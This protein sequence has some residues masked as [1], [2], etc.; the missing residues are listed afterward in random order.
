[1]PAGSRPVDLPSGFDIGGGSGAGWGKS[2]DGPVWLPDPGC[3]S[4]T[5]AGLS[6]R[7]TWSA[8]GGFRVIN[9][10]TGRAM[11]TAA[12]PRGRL[13]ACEWE[14]GRVV[15]H[16]PGGGLTV[17]AERLDGRRLNHPD[18]LAIASDGTVYF[19]DTR[20]VTHRAAAGDTIGRSGVYRLTPG[21]PPQPLP[22]DLVEPGGVALSPAED[23]LYV[24]DPRTSRVLALP[25][26][27]GRAAARTLATLPIGPGPARPLGIAVDRL[28]NLYTGGP[29]GV[30]VLDA[31]GE[32]LGV[33]RH[34]ASR[35][36]N[37]AFGGPEGR[38]LFITSLVGA[39]TVEVRV[40]GSSVPRPA[41]VGPGRPLAMPVTVER[42][43]P[44][45][46]RVIAPGTE[47]VEL[48]S[49][50]FSTDLGGGDNFWSRSLEGT[51]WSHA[52]GALL[53]SDIGNSRILRWS[54]DGVLSVYR[55][56]TGHANG[57][58]LDPMGRLVS[59][60]QGPERRV[61][62]LEPDGTVTV[63]ADSWDGRRLGRPNDVVVA[64]DGAIYFTAP[65][66]DFG[67]GATREIE[68][69]GVFRVSPDLSTVSPVVRDFQTPNGL[70]FSVD[71]KVLFV[72]D[73]ARMQIRGFAVR[74]D[75]TLDLAT[76]RVFFQFP[77]AHDDGLGGP[78]GMKVDLEG[79]VY[80]GGPGGLWIIDP[81]GRHLGTLRHGATQTNNLCFGD[82]DW[83]TLYWVSWSALYSI[84]LEV[85]GVPVP[86]G[87][88]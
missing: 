75:G 58:T 43:D 60:E 46:D 59:C 23:L 8:A 49:G 37:L 69:N 65:W 34:S 12:D 7:L 62:R 76:D 40:E 57:S 56:P 86:R 54:P 48:A 47:I 41:P 61:T 38:T 10:A 80:C 11:G 74:P 71:E 32:V 50:G 79:N 81:S 35:T 18:D 31:A 73:T 70:A 39:A 2:I 24:S 6:R 87:A 82:D 67:E 72:N 17:L 55:R 36:A 42:A 3:W 25:L 21:E 4:F 30:W 68:F 14:R 85:A 33:I 13:V 52:D 78:D 22:I 77:G 51:F 53:F 88:V 45:L 16:E 83:K 20:I 27:G 26:D 84:R 66:W 44:A 9:E 15:R 19:T 64:S 63:V 29:G 1:V 5:D 28:G